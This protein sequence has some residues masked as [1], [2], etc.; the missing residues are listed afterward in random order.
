MQ[1]FPKESPLYCNMLMFINVT[2]FFQGL[3]IRLEHSHGFSEHGE[4][5]HYHYDVTPDEVKYRGYFN[6]AENLYK[7]DRPTNENDNPFLEKF[8]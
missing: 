8:K 3:N 7:I 2:W 1:Y 5:G 4:G 6:I